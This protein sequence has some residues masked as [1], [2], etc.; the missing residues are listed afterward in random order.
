MTQE[1]AM[2]I[3]PQHRRGP[4]PALATNSQ[5]ATAGDRAKATMVTADGALNV[6]VSRLRQ[7]SDGKIVTKFDV[8]GDIDSQTAPLLVEAL[9]Q[10]IER[11]PLVCCDFTKVV[12]FGAEGAHVLAAADQ[13]GKAL[14]HRLVLYGVHGTALTVMRIAGLDSLIAAG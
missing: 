3:D 7:N 14:G 9:R 10:V 12:F 4:S 1:H 11:E 5:A 13:L 8:E 6:T 2:P